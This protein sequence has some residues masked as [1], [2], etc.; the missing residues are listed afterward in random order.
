VNHEI[1]I[2]KKKRGKKKR[3]LLDGSLL[4]RE[5]VILGGMFSFVHHGLGVFPGGGR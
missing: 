2:K 3:L 1:A 4:S 5:A